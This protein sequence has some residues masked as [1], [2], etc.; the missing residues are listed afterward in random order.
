MQFCLLKGHTMTNQS[1]HNHPLRAAR[2]A[3]LMY[4][5]LIP[6]GVLAM[7]YVPTNLL[8]EGDIVTTIA[9]LKANEMMFRLASVS[10][11]ATQ[12]VNLYLVVLLYNLLKPVSKFA[13]RAMAILIIIGIPIAWVT[14]L[15]HAAIL[16]LIESAEPSTQLVSMFLYM[17]KYGINIASI[18]WGLWLFPM[19]YLVFRSNFI[20]KIIGILLMI[21]CFGYLG[22]SFI[23]FINPDSEIKLAQYLFVGELAMAFWLLIRGVNVEKWHQQVALAK[24]NMVETAVK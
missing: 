13:A 23:F 15:N 7:I 5:L 17:H 2:L 11:F 6:L 14:E 18:L 4:V 19:G 21:G 20:P 24:N 22:D 3:G 8:V 9:N 12:L 16:F 1:V 10:A